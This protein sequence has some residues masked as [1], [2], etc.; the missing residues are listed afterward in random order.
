[1]FFRIIADVLNGGSISRIAHVVDITGQ[2]KKN[3]QLLFLQHL[4]NIT[5]SY[6][7]NVVV[8]FP[9]ESRPLFTL[10]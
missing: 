2:L 7:V 10:H 4:I 8:Y 6:I 3:Y 1:M 5:I 9:H